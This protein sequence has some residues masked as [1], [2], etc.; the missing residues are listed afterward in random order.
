MV[1]KSGLHKRK[2]NKIV[3]AKRIGMWPTR[4]PKYDKDQYEGE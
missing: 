2:N 3:A 4:K 1:G